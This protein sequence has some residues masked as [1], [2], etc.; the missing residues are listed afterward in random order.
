MRIGARTVL[1]IVHLGIA[2][3]V[4]SAGYAQTIINSPTIALRSGE[5]AELGATY[6]VVNCRSILKS[7]PEVEILDGPPGVSVGIKAPATRR[8]RFGSS[9][10][11]AMAIGSPVKS[12]IFRCFHRSCEYNATR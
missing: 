6:W 2:G 12:I 1:A 8:S 11:V 5:S 10:A 7:T 9:T 3:T 4:G